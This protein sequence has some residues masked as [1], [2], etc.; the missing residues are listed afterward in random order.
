MC[1]AI[2]KPAGSTVD[3]ATLENCWDSNPHGA[4]FM[5]SSGGRVHVRK[6]YMSW[7]TLRQAWIKHERDHARHGAVIHF[8]WATHGGKTTENTHPHKIRP[9]LWMVHNGVLDVQIPAGSKQSDTAHYC[10]DILASMPAAW[11]YRARL[12]RRLAKQI[13]T[14]N[15]M[16]LLN[17]A[18][19]V[20]IV[21]EDLGVW[22]AGVWY[23]N[24]GY[25]RAPVRAWRRPVAWNVGET[26]IL[27]NDWYG[28]EDD[29]Q[30]GMECFHDLCE[31]CGIELQGY[32]E[33]QTGTC[34]SC[35]V[36]YRARYAQEELF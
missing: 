17:A 29:D 35:Q 28:I 34:Y 2:Y 33:K 24:T 13:G 18:G 32:T 9:D 8:R 4:G 16:I 36:Y 27:N 19:L 5:W 1:I 25:K 22:D 10:Q 12:I 15:K 3:L 31:D 7:R 23:S 21:N 26:G 11:E 20:Q 6:G 30:I 14:G